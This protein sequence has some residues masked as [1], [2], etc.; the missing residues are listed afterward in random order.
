MKVNREEL[1]KQ[2]ESVTAGLSTRE[3]VEQSSCFVFKNKRAITYN[4]EM[5]CSI[6]CC[7]DVEGAIQAMPLLNILRKLKEDDLIITVDN[8]ELHIK[9]K[10]RWAGIRLEKEIQLPIDSVEEPGKWKTLPEK[11]TEGLAIVEQCAGK[12]EAF[13]YVTCIH[14]C[15][16]YIEACDNHQLSRYYM[17][18]GVKEPTLVKRDSL[19]HLI[20]L[21]MTKFSMTAAWMHFKNPAGL[22]IS[23]R[24]Y[25]EEEYPN[26]GKELKHEGEKIILPKGLKEAAERAQVFSSENPESDVISVKIRPGKIKVEG[27]GVSGW[28][29]E[30][31]KVKY[32]GES[33]S[34]TITPKLLMELVQHHNECQILEKQTEKRNIKRLIVIGE[35]FKY[36]TCLGDAAV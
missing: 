34:F 15:P 22:M 14:I 24:R 13:F 36:V 31:K 4:D 6:D 29:R 30:S 35:N 1:L 20:A 19:K 32:N 9:G 33:L 7:L 2:L 21:D 18:T 12:E 5:A 23:C 17:E 26:T 25:S 10:K 11:F 28:F 27:I 16:D 3:T 8:N